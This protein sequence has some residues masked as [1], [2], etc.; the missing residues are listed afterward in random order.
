[1]AASRTGSAVRVPRLHHRLRGLDAAR[2]VG[3][4]QAERADGGA[5]GG[6]NAIVEADGGEIGRRR[7]DDLVGQGIVDGA[8]GVA[9]EDLLVRGVDQQAAVGQRLDDRGGVRDAGTRDGVDTGGGIVETVLGNECE[10]GGEILGRCRSA[11]WLREP[12]AH[13]C[14]DQEGD[15]SKPVHGA[16]IPVECA[17][18]DA[19]SD[20]LM[21]F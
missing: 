4:H 10:A 18:L 3:V 14:R 2:W 13:Q 21:V 16:S 6:A 1:M 15:T 8:G 19:P 5:G 9:I 7:G 20:R 12:A 17:E 11:L